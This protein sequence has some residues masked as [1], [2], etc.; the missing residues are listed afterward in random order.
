MPPATEGSP[1][2]IA[3]ELVG[4]L[5]ELCGSI[6]NYSFNIFAYRVNKR[7]KMLSDIRGYIEQD[8]TYFS[9][10]QRSTLLDFLQH[11]DMIIKV[12]AKAQVT[13]QPLPTTSIE[14][15]LNI[16]EIWTESNL[17]PKDANPNRITLL[18]NADTWLAESA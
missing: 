16:Y 1:K 3:N 13:D 8:Q 12:V 2:V 10:E 17:L 7:E 14:M 4:S 15:L 6:H 11:V 5:I 18:D 9:S